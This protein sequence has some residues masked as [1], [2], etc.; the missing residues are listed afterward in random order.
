MKTAAAALLLTACTT[1]DYGV[2]KRVAPNPGTETP[3][4]LKID[5][6]FQEH[7]YGENMTRCQVQVAFKPLRE[8]AEEGS[9]DGGGH[10][11]GADD[12]PQQGDPGEERPAGTHVERPRT[13]G[14][15]VFSEVERPT[16]GGG[17]QPGGDPG[18][19]GSGGDHDHEGGVDD[20]QVSGQ[21]IGPEQ[22]F[23]DS[24]PE[25]LSLVAV[26][27]DQ[28]G[29]RY[30]L[31]GCDAASFPF[32]RTLGLDVPG[33]QDPDGVHAFE[34]EDL[35]A[36]GPRVVLDHPM[37]DA[38]G[39][40]PI[41]DP[42]QDLEVRWTMDGADPVVDGVAVEPKTLIQIQH[43]AVDR[44]ASDRWLVCWPEEE[45]WFDVPAEALEPL[46]EGREDPALWTTHIDVH[47]EGAGA[48]QPT[49]WGRALQVRAHVSA[50]G[51]VTL[52]AD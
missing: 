23:V 50:G 25:R 17:G 28:G 42:A 9:H 29:V 30:E 43:Q 19:P 39:R 31:A 6:A 40:H 37:R 4:D 20:W 45:G 14:E 22:V 51:G 35:I 18:E 48:E 24:G 1:T 27:T 38:D 52:R 33:S 47:T 46:L 49:P 13:P 3:V 2:G 12:G 8:Q 16:P 10:G 44:Q 7:G 11:D 41:L 36:V 21:V 32:S 15:C 26:D 5:V 34:M